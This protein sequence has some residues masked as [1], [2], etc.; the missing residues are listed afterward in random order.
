M[1]SNTKILSLT[2]LLGCP[3]ISA[4]N[5]KAA[6]SKSN[7]P[8]I[9]AN[10][11]PAEISTKQDRPVRFG[12]AIG[13]EFI[14]KTARGQELLEGAQ[15]T[16]EQLSNKLKQEEDEF[17]RRM[18]EFNAKKTLITESARDAEE[19]ELKRM[20]HLLELAR[21]DANNQMKIVWQK[22]NEEMSAE[23]RKSAQTIAMQFDLDVIQDPITREFYFVKSD[24]ILT[25]LLVAETNKNPIKPASVVVAKK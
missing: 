18:Q 20:A 9:T 23:I 4:E 19:L 7:I 14:Q 25:D 10:T 17:N 5:T 2:L 3:I 12:F 1:N 24:I 6:P 13:G 22:I 8:Q 11:T 21:E 16:A 15:K